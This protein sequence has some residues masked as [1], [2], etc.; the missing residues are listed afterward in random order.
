ME[1]MHGSFVANKWLQL[2]GSYQ[3]SRPDVLGPLSEGVGPLPPPSLLDCP[4]PLRIPAVG[5]M[6]KIAPTS[7]G[8]DTVEAVNAFDAKV[9]C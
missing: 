7:I 3:V 2:H 8:M 5:K 1:S 4:Y 6:T 9:G